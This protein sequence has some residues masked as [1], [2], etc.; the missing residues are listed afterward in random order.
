MLKRY[1]DD[2]SN[3][4]GIVFKQSS[5][6]KSFCENLFDCFMYINFVSLVALFCFSDNYP[7]RS[8]SNNIV[9][10]SSLFL[11]ID[12]APFYCFMLI[13]TECV[14]FHLRVSDTDTDSDNFIFSRKST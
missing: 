1:N 5:S 14:S 9:L 6:A 3:T 2:Y 4:T 10:D 11:T 12:F 13:M 7:V 8:Y